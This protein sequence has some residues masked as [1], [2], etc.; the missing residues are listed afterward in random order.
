MI[1]SSFSSIYN[2]AQER[3]AFKEEFLNQFGQ[4]DSRTMPSFFEWSEKNL[5]VFEFFEF[6]IA[7]TK[8]GNKPLSM[9]QQ[10]VALIEQT[11]LDWA[12]TLG[13]K[14]NLHLWHSSILFFIIHKDGL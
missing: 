3:E 1:L 10:Y 2:D 14:V 5:W 12:M 8:L 6:F 11:I 7:E 13:I 9:K 4:V